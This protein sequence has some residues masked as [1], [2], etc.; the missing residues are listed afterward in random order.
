MAILPYVPARVQQAE[1]PQGKRQ[2]VD[3]VFVLWSAAFR[4]RLGFVPIYSQGI[5][6]LQEAVID[7]ERK[8]HASLKRL[9]TTA[10]TVN[11]VLSL[12]AGYCLLNL[13][14]SLSA[15]AET[16]EY[17]PFH[18]GIRSTYVFCGR[19]PCV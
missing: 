10:F 18:V 6:A 17:D 5:D 11:L 13:V 2:F 3:D 19:V 14:S 7:K 9:F 8:R 15:Q 4:V 16:A 1:I 12:V